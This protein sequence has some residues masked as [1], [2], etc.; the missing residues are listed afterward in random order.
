MKTLRD[1]DLKNKRVLVR[2]DFNVPLDG[3]GN[4]SD[5]FRI[6]KTVPTI[7]YLIENGAKVILMSHLGRPEGRVEEALRLTPVQDKLTE[8]LDVSVAKAPDCVGEEIEKWTREMQPGEI[9]LLENLRFHKEEE[10]NDDIFARKLA[11]LGDIYINDA[12]GVSH[13]SHASVVG[14]A[15]YLPSGAGLL[16]EKEIKTLSG[17][18]DAPEKPLV[19]VIGGAKV[20][21]KVG[22]VNKIS[23][24]AD[25]VLVGGL[26]I[27]SIKGEKIH[28]AHP[29]KI[30]EPIDEIGGG[31]DIGPETV[32]LFREKISQA[33][34]VFFN[35]ALGQIESEEFSGGTEE[36]LR[37]I[38]ESQAFSV[39]GGGDMM[40]L[41]ARLGLS[42][43]FN[44][45]STGG[46]AMLAL[47]SGQKLPGL[48]ALK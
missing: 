5:D 14:V 48:E 20:E 46:G 2:C 34:T 33:K 22:L 44:H 1:F 29:E 40:F 38:S 9:L 25:C 19:A 15:Q 4:I 13:R 12:F 42:E 39:V 35:G 7:S 31:K 27:K 45:I 3:Q 37:A 21:T 6:K 32:E 26:I 36:I 24:T 16:L 41:I 8:Y 43:K 18:I 30:V 23:G 17:L 11:S 10:E 28:L 47:L